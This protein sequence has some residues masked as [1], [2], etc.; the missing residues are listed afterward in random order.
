M[1]PEEINDSATGLADKDEGPRNGNP[2]D[3]LVNP[4]EGERLEWNEGD[5]I[6]VERHI[7]GEEVNNFLVL[8][9]SDSRSVRLTW[10]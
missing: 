5:I 8:Y 2:P 10:N 6:V 1:S 9:F 4:G 3:G 7:P